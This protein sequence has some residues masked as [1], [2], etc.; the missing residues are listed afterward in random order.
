M[1]DYFSQYIEVTKLATTTTAG[2][3]GTLKPIFSRLGISDV[4]I[5]DN[6]PQFILH[7]IKV[8]WRFSHFT[9]SPRYPQS[10]G[11]AKWAVQT[12]KKLLT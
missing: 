8:I 10:N 1:V 12:V 7:E 2:V 11:Q 9:S 6:R 5:S 4:F 3:I